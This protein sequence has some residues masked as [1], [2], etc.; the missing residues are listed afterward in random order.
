MKN[1]EKTDLNDQLFYINTLRVRQGLQPL[2]GKAF[3]R[4]RRKK[5]NEPKN[6]NRDRSHTASQES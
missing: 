5:D 3:R 4:L 2:D 6:D 1:Q